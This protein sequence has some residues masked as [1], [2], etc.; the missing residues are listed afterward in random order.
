MF[1]RYCVLELLCILVAAPLLA[2][3]SPESA[4]PV[5]Q[6]FTTHCYRCHGQNSS[7]QGGLSD[8]TDL[9]A[10][11]TS[12]L[13]VPGKPLESLIFKRI[14]PAL[15]GDMPDDELSKPSDAEI[16]SVRKWI[17]N[18]AVVSQEQET[19]NRPFIPVQKEIE[20]IEEFLRNE[21][22]TADRN[23]Y[24]FFS[25]RTLHNAS[26][27]KVRDSDLRLY[28]AALSKLINSLSWHKKIVIPKA[29]D[30]HHLVFAVNIRELGWLGENDDSW[31]Q[32]LVRYPYG[33]TH[34]RYPSSKKINAAWEFITQS[35]Q[36]NVPSVRADWFISNASRPPLYHELLKLPNNLDD[37]IARLPGPDGK[38][39][40]IEENIQRGKVVRS[41]F[42]GSGVSD[43]NNR[44][45][46]RHETLYGS[47]W[48]SYDFK[49]SV[50]RGNL[51]VFPLGPDFANNS[52][53]KFA[54]KHDG[55]ELIFSLPNRM[56]AYFLVDSKG[57]RIDVGPVEIVSDGKHKISGTPAIVNGLSCIACHKNGMIRKYDQ[58]RESH[59]LGGVAK[60]KI[61]E[62]FKTDAALDAVFLEDE[63]RFQKSLVD[64]TRPFLLEGSHSEKSIL[65]LPEPVGPIAKWYALEEMS[66][67]DVCQEL[68]GVPVEVLTSAISNN[69]ELQLSGLLPLTKG[70]K[71][72]REV[73]ESQLLIFSTYQSTAIKLKLGEPISSR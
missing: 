37:L 66:I 47:L 54:F 6:F 72:K 55:G 65:D 68:D 23:S 53:A 49:S 7:A 10:L 40:T 71:I 28:K 19:E 43:R 31:R 56:Q 45:I 24:R 57:S 62:I 59:V 69:E 12:G 26:T 32:V 8:V 48:I 41:A 4:E 21:V 5:R 29:I 27:R 46:E 34:E 58:V 38:A 52:F 1:I 14:S 67:N 25:F 15:I 70:K 16:E 73:W 42:N 64:A 11:L 17:E 35:T 51:F 2:N 63:N 33:L 36:S 13:V 3:E 20:S 18:G 39:W 9:H 30:E 22:A 44:L 61:D 50:G 60:S